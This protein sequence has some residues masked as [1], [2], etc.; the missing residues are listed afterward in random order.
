L[1][2]IEK[3]IVYVFNLVRDLNDELLDDI[4]DLDIDSVYCPLE[5][6]SNGSEI[7]V[8]FYGNELWQNYNDDRKW[9]TDNERENL[10][11]FITRKLND[12]LKIIKQLNMK[13]IIM[14]ETK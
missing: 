9:I 2:N 1:S 7:K 10:R 5:L 11:V 4:D 8:S 12:H 13:Q 3:E 6:I 14:K